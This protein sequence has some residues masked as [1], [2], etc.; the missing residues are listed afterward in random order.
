MWKESRAYEK[1]YLSFLTFVPQTGSSWRELGLGNG[2]GGASGSG[3]MEHSRREETTVP[4]ALEG[5]S[6]SEGTCVWSLPTW[7]G[8][9]GTEGNG[10]MQVSCCNSGYG[11]HS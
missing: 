11:C 5:E 10:P 9:G 1:A 8:S 3:D 4:Q 2:R 7:R 6:A